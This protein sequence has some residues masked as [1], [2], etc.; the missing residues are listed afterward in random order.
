LKIWKEK[1][2][3]FLIL[4]PSHPRAREEVSLDT[5]E[6]WNTPF[7]DV[8]LDRDLMNFLDIPRSSDAQ[9]GEHSTEVI[10]HY[11]KPEVPF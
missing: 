5:H 3:T 6:A 7:G 2:D 9:H 1:L 10:L 11:E 4:N 8:T